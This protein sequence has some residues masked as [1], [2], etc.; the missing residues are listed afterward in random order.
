MS[1]VHKDIV[2]N[3]ETL[4]MPKQVWPAMNQ[5]FHAAANRPVDCSIVNELDAH[6]DREFP[7][8]SAQELHDAIAHTTT[9]STPGWDHIHWRHLK[10]LIDPKKNPKT[11]DQILEGF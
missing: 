4:A 11:A 9:T 10:H 6:N 1:S 8:F 7:P 5:A 3:G 2:H